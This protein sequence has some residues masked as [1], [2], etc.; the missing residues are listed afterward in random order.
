MDLKIFV[1]IFLN[2]LSSHIAISSI[3]QN[4]QSNK[5]TKQFLKQKIN[6]KIFFYYFVINFFRDVLSKYYVVTSKLK[7]IVLT[8]LLL[9]ISENYILHIRTHID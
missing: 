7:T 5:K 9:Y 2:Y 4:F 1:F 6:Y 3:N 8:I